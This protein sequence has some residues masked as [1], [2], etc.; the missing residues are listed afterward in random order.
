MAK[1][2]IFGNQDLA[3]LAHYYFKQGNEHEVVAFTLDREFIS[4]TTFEGLPIVPFEEIREKFSPQDH[5]LFAPITQKKMGKVRAEKFH[6]GKKW[7]YKFATYI[8]PKVTRYPNNEIGENCFIFEDN[9]IQ[10]FVSIGDNCILWSGNHI[11]HHSKLGSHIFITSHVVISG[12]VNVGDCSFFGVNATVRDALNIGEGTLV[13]MGA[14]I[15]KDTPP[16]S[17]FAQP[18]P[19]VQKQ[20]SSLD[21]KGF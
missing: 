18:Q 1:L 4:E 2:V 13:G 3:S 15:V 11:G 17:V 19:A 5:M 7:G 12:H 10:P 8:S 14:L 9:T 16:Y 21:V 20:M 6:Q